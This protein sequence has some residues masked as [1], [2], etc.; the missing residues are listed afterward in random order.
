MKTVK[1]PEG[2][3]I[4]QIQGYLS[5][6]LESMAAQFAACTMSPEDAISAA[7]MIGALKWIETNLADLYANQHARDSLADLPEVQNI[8]NKCEQY[9]NES[10]IGDAE[11][12][13]ALSFIHKEARNIRTA[14]HHKCFPQ[15]DILDEQFD[16]KCPYCHEHHNPECEACGGTGRIA[17]LPKPI[18]EPLT[19]MHGNGFCVPMEVADRYI[20]AIKKLTISSSGEAEFT[21]RYREL[22]AAQFAYDA[23]KKAKP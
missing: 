21:V 7:I 19:E 20:S 11:V 15:A 23:A 8:M 4:E 2:V 1:L 14:E 18:H 16:A 12:H 9:W 10:G 5:S 6:M 17:P 22:E 3:S 13:A